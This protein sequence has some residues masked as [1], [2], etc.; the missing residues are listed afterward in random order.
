[1]GITET[2]TYGYIRDKNDDQIINNQIFL[3]DYDTHFALMF[4]SS[5]N[6]IPYIVEIPIDIL[7]VTAKILKSEYH[8][9]NYENNSFIYNYI[10]ENEKI[11]DDYE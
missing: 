10:K 9:L 5:H 3:Y 6:N 1:M 2:Y 11:L 4:S 7:P 8:I